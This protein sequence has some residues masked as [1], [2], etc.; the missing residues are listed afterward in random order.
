MYLRTTQRKNKDG[1]V[2]RYYA[3]AHNERDPV[4]RKP[5]AH[6]IHSFGRAD[7]LDRGQLVRLCRSIA[8]VCDLHVIDS[9]VDAKGRTKDSSVG[10]PKDLKL[11]RIFPI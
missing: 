10:L 11:I 6:I 5:V 1:S 9:L 4:T 7:E 3:L 8:R 2:V